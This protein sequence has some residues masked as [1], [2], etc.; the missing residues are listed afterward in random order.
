MRIT[1]D[2]NTESTGFGYVE[3]GPQRLR[4]VACDHLQGPKHP[5]LKWEFEI[6][7]PNVKATDQKSRPGHIFEN[8]TLKSGDNAQFRLK[9]VCDALGVDWGDFETEEMIGLELEAQL[10]IREYQ[11][12]MSNE[13]NKFV[14]VEK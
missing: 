7:D 2:P 13:V 6:T 12:T 8:T 14:P 5:Y 9:Q 11:G 10:G 4:V 1:V 3:A